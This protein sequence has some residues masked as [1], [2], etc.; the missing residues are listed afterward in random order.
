MGVE[1][2][3]DDDVL[4]AEEEEEAGFLSDSSTHSFPCLVTKYNNPRTTTATTEER[5]G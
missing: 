2:V 1:G 5:G 3:A 4:A